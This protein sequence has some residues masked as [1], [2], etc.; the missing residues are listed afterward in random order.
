MSRPP[1][2]NLKICWSVFVFPFV[3]E[4]MTFLFPDLLS[5]F[6]IIRIYDRFWVNYCVL[7][8]ESKGVADR[9]RIGVHVCRAT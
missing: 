9:F 5:I 2:W 1:L 4:L 3:C 6:A 7:G 8:F